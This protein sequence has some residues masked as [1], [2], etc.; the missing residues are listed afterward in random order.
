MTP[1]APTFVG[2]HGTSSVHLPSIRRGIQPP[3]GLNFGGGAQ[4]GNGFYVTLT[5]DRA[6]WFAVSATFDLGGQPIV[7]AVALREFDSL[8]GL[9]VPQDI[10][11]RVPAAYIIDYDYL[12]SEIDGMAP[13]RQLKVNPRAYGQLVIT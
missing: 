2:Y 4:L 10:W 9:E 6:R 7:L 5:Y 11:W 1:T 3:T 13:A 12:T 8:R